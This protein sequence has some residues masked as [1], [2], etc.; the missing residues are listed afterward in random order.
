MASASGNGNQGSSAQ[1]G[2]PPATGS[3]VSS[4]G[5]SGNLGRDVPPGSS[6]S[7]AGVKSPSTGSPRQNQQA[8]GDGSGM[9][10]ERPQSNDD[11]DDGLVDGGTR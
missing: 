8:N 4:V 9:A 3:S 7:G 11:E 6:G 2:Q 1:G 10:D 5:S